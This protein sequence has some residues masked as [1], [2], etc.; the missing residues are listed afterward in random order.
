MDKAVF[1]ATKSPLPAY[2][3]ITFEHPE[4]TAP[5]R[6]VANQFAPVTLGGNVHTPAPMTVTPPDQR[7]DADAKMT[8]AFP[9]AVVGREFK[10]QIALIGGSRDPITIT[11]AIYLGDTTTPERTWIMY[12]S[13]AGG[14]RFTAESVQV[15]ATVDNPMRRQVAPTYD[16]AVF[17]GLAI[18]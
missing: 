4:F 16:P 7:S 17:T 3:S 2:E 13:D 14:I 9:R 5:F 15:V 8:L 1:Y 10:R 12:A 18:L 6:L 11:Y